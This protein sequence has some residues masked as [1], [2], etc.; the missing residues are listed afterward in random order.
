[1]RSLP[2]P[3]LVK[4]HRVEAFGPSEAKNSTRYCPSYRGRGPPRHRRAGMPGGAAA[5]RC[6]HYESRSRDRRMV[7]SPSFIVRARTR[8]PLVLRGAFR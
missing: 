2:S 4:P 6:A 1:M 7:V 5:H 3:E 8:F